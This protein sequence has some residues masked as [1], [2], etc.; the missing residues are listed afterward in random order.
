MIRNLESFISVF[1]FQYPNVNVIH[2][3]EYICYNPTVPGFFQH[4]ETQGF[5]VTD[6]P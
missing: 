4:G 3:G 5:E 1:K 6:L 2:I